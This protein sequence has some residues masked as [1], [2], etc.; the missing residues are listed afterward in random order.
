MDREKY[1]RWLTLKSIK[2]SNKIILRGVFLLR[3]HELE[4]F[5]QYGA[6]QIFPEAWQEYIN[7]ID[8]DKRDNLIL[9][10]SNLQA[11]MKKKIEGYNSINVDRRQPVI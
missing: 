8:Y 2:I 3:Q 7:I 11:T 4:W 1:T 5:Y 10:K 9:A 6:S